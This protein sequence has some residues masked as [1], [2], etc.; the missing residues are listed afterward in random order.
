MQ[1]PEKE[2]I[3]GIFLAVFQPSAILIIWLLFGFKS[4]V[5]DQPANLCL[6]VAVQAAGR[7]GLLRVHEQGGAARQPGEGEAAPGGGGEEDRL[8]A[9]AGRGGRGREAPAT[10]REGNIIFLPMQ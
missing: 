4:S 10:Q 1:F 6:S 3:N 7:P 8:G 2:Y 5:R 9:E